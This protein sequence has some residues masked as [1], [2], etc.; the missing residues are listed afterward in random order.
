VYLPIGSPSSFPAFR[1]A[2]TVQRDTPMVRA[3]AAAVDRIISVPAI[4]GD[5]TRLFTCPRSF[6]FIF[7]YGLRP[8]HEQRMQHTADGQLVPT[9]GVKL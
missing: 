6:E 4:P 1:I 3:C 8:G 9:Y 2:W 7:E 5:A